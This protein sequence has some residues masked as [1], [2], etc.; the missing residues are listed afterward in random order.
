MVTPVIVTPGMEML[1]RDRVESDSD[2][3]SGD[4]VVE[5]GA[6]ESGVAVP[7]VHVE[8]TAPLLM[9]PLRSPTQQIT[10]STF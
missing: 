4:S 1:V 10:P 9:D 2:D 7:A 3:P 6:S 5:V 8:N